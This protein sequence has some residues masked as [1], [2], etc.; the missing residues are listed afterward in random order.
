MDA[1]PPGSRRLDWLALWILFCSGCSISGWALSAVGCLNRP[2]YIAAFCAFVGVLFWWGKVIGFESDSRVRKPFWLLRSRWKLPKAWVLLFAL[3]ALGGVIY[4]PNN[5]DYLTYRFPRVLHWWSEQG[6]YWIATINNRQN[7]SGT[8]FEW[9]MEPVFVF[10]KTDRLFFLINLISYLLLPGLIFSVFRQLGISG[11]VSWW[12][13]WLLP[14]GYCFALQAASAGNDSFAAVYALGSIYYA[15]RSKGSSSGNLAL[16]IFSVALLTGAKAANLPL[17]LPWALAI[18]LNRGRLFSK[19]RPGL[20]VVTCILALL[21]SFLPTALFNIRFTGDYTG[22][23]NNSGKMKV[24]HPVSGIIGNG[25]QLAAFNLAPPIWPK[26][27][28]W[29]PL[30]PA[31]IKNLLQQ[32]FPRCD[33]APGEMQIEEVAGIGLGLTAFAGLILGMGLTNRIIL[34]RKGADPAATHGGWIA[35]GAWVAVLVYMSKIGSE[36][37]PRLIAAYYPLLL[38]GVLR[39]A[40]LD[41]LVTGRRLF[42]T[43][44]WCAV[45]SAFPLIILNP[46]R[47]LFPIQIVQSFLSSW[48]VPESLRNRYEQVYG[49]YASRYDGY[50]KLNPFIPPAEQVVGFMT[51]GNDPEAPLWRPFG[52]RSIVEVTADE[53]REQLLRD[54]VQIVVVGEDGLTNNFHS[55]IE[56][57]TERWSAQVVGKAS[58]THLASRGA[59]VW[60]VIRFNKP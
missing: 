23:P 32:D 16:S 5:Y 58:M 44:G 38:A 39:L 54:H 35:A 2:G 50:S 45:L 27:S 55:N 20:L 3:I 13:M 53:S 21:A 37:G 29:Y 43:V 15:L 6:W 49:V 22:D 34:R 1:R 33:L 9:L 31:D 47:P 59:E 60:Y 10:F 56:E 46:A 41:G 25:L 51:N 36:S 7:Y 52:S 40:S 17:V 8:G 28:N 57:L 42:K 19:L 14:A 12:W 11:R 30:L 18:F 26:S 4:P 24:E 48:N